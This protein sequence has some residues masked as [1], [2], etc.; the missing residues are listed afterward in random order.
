MHFAALLCLLVASPCMSIPAMPNFLVDDT[1]GSLS[2]SEPPSPLSHRA[3]IDMPVEEA[4][5]ISARAEDFFPAAHAVHKSKE[6]NIAFSRP[7]ASSSIDEITS[8]PGY[9]S[10]LASK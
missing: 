6:L 5:R 4:Q 2:A 9:K 10:K 3:S 1:L 8:F 7:I